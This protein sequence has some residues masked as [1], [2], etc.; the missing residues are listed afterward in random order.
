MARQ[1]PKPSM[2]CVLR[3][4]AGARARPAGRGEGASFG[5]AYGALPTWMARMSIRGLPEPALADMSRAAAEQ[6][7]ARAPAPRP[8]E[9]RHLSSVVA[10]F[11]SCSSDCSCCASSSTRPSRLLARSSHS[12]AR[13]PL[14]LS[15][16]RC[17]RAATGGGDATGGCCGLAATCVRQ[18]RPAIAG[19]RS[20]GA[21]QCGRGAGGGRA[22]SSVGSAP[23]LRTCRRGWRCVREC[24]GS[25]SSLTQRPVKFLAAAPL[26]SRCA[27]AA[28][29]AICGQSAP[30]GALPSPPRCYPIAPGPTRKFTRVRDA[31]RLPSR[32]HLR[33]PY[34]SPPQP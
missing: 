34:S 15:V 19:Q 28:C 10:S 1:T 32:P 21:G 17:W 18:R 3:R 7:R 29:T 33:K 4:G 16:M 9:E 25:C 11:I 22:E 24:G 6:A 23:R 2:R 31:C 26:P 27:P 13:R 8:S 12:M 5:A 30:S 14:L 20:G